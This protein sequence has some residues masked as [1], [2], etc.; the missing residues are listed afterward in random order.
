ML[1][2]GAIDCRTRLVIVGST[3]FGNQVFTFCNTAHLQESSQRQVKASDWL[4]GTVDL[5][6]IRGMKIVE[7]VLDEGFCLRF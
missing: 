3:F 7:K 5:D 2:L 1:H 4:D 6:E